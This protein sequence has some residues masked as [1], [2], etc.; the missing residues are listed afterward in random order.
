MDSSQDTHK[1][2]MLLLDE[3]HASY[4]LINHEPQGQTD[5]VSALRGH[6][7]S[8]AAKCIIIMV[9][10]GKKQKKFV[11]AVIPGDRRVNLNAIKN[12]FKGTYVGFASNDVAETLAGSVSGT[13]LPFSF[14]PELELIVDPM[15]LH[16]ETLYFNAAQLDCSLA[17]STADYRTIARPR[18][19]DIV[20]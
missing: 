6:N 7:P 11:L 19:E 18:I 9:K 3:H 1:R 16:N 13:V 14:N 12:L 17:L 2:L 4:R 20:E 10:I 5:L 8:E 15:L